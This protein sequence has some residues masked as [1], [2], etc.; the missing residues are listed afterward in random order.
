MPKNRQ[1]AF[2][3]IC[4]IA[5]EFVSQVG[6]QIAAIAIPILVLQFTHSS[7]ATGIAGAG[8]IIPI[9]LAAFVG[10]KLI[11]RFGVWR[12]SVVADVLSGF[13]VMLLP[14]MFIA[15]KSVSPIVIFG[16]VFAG[17]LF[18]PTAVSAR[19]ILVPKFSRLAGVSLDKVNGYRGSLENG[20]DLLGP[21]VG[22]GLVS[23]IGA[24]DTL[25][26]NAVSFFICA[27]L[28]AIAVPRLRQ[29][30]VKSEGTKPIAGIRFILQQRQ[31]RSLTLSGMV[32]SFVLLPFLGLLLPVLVTQ[33]FSAA[34]L[35]IC[36]AGFGM[37]AT[38]G[39]LSYSTLTQR[40]SRSTIYYSGLL[41]TAIAILLCAIVK[42]P[43]ALLLAV[44]LGGLILGAGN[45]L[46]Q[47][48]LQEVT[49]VRIAGQ[50]FASHSAISSTAGFVGF[51][52]AGVITELTS[53]EWVLSLS[54]SLL[55]VAAAM[56]WYFLPLYPAA[57]GE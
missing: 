28:F 29:Q 33:K 23:W 15:F 39:A 1:G 57:V 20:A 53:V 17:A 40:F 36:L 18:D 31:L 32:L 24:V 52:I 19:H 26:M 10:G 43:I 56:G 47:T 12:V 21:V 14:F 11:D 6:N 41:L 5:A 54:G 48:I 22:A 50:V 30:F 25:F 37:A 16:L 45:P 42:T 27:V 3:L 9:V 2:P 8:N 49:P 51:L 38:L 13:S 55:A 4:L 7:T 46:E 44:G 35:G 34:L